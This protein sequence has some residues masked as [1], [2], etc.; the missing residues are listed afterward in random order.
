MENVYPFVT[1]DGSV[2]LYNAE[3]DDI[4]HSVKGAYTE[5]WDKFTEAAEPECY[6]DSL[7]TVRVLDICYGIGYNTKSLLQ[8]YF[9]YEKKILKNSKKYLKKNKNKNSSIDT[10]HSDNIKSKFLSKLFIDAVETDKN[11]VACSPLFKIFKKYNPKS[12]K[13]P[14]SKNQKYLENKVK[15]KYKFENFIDFFILMKL[16]DSDNFK[17]EF[18]ALKDDFII[19]DFREYFDINKWAYLQFLLFQRYSDTFKWSLST[20]VHNIY[21]RYIS[22]CYKKALKAFRD[23]D[24]DIS[25]NICDAR[26]YVKS[27]PNTYNLIF[28][29]AFTTNKCPCLWTYDFIKELFRLLDDN[30]KLI[31]YSNAAHVRNAMLMA[32]FKVG[33]IYNKSENKFTGTIA[34]K[35]ETL[36]KYPLTEDDLSLIKSKAGIVYRD[37]NLNAEN[38]AIL[39]ERENNVKNS[40]LVSSSQALKHSVEVASDV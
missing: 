21:Y 10:I 6:L 5:A 35:D 17:E 37:T 33:K 8:K 25:F 20:F 1:N 27:T 36:I 22:N 24:I 28:L 30:G 38:G 39:V 32:G 3:Y 15:N 13:L 11:L 19:S 40:S 14:N 16:A 4:Y 31:T 34:V 23:N 29:D 7:D 12:Q 2:G 26:E 9:L 18:K